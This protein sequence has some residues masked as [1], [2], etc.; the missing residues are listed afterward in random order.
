M[1]APDRAWPARFAF[2]YTRLAAAPALSCLTHP[3][4]RPPVSFCSIDR[5]VMYL[6]DDDNVLTIASAGCNTLDYIIDGAR[7]T[8]V[9]LNKAQIALTEAKV[10]A[11][12]HLP[13][14]D[15]FRIFGDCDMDHFRALYPTHLRE[16]MRESSQVF[17]DY[18]IHRIQNLMWSGASGYLAWITFRVLFPLFGL[19]FVIKAV[20]DD[21]PAEEFREV[22]AGNKTRSFRRRPTAAIADPLS[23]DPSTPPLHHVCSW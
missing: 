19:G 9:D 15:Y 12:C 3:C 11:I 21:M 7:V 2:L 16:H 22:R 20:N 1:R 6:T 5:Q 4:P 14:E 23:L 13:F 17:W 18:K 10:A 8:A